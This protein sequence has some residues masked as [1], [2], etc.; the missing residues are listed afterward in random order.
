[1]FLHQ[2]TGCSGFKTSIITIFISDCSYLIVMIYYNTPGDVKWDEG[3]V[4]GA[5]YHGETDLTG[6]LTKVPETLIREVVFL[7]G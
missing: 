2:S 6:I 5:V 1:M 4:S 7:C 3:R